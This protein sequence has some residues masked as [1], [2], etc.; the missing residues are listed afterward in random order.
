MRKLNQLLERN[1]TGK[2]VLVLF[3][4]TSGIY[5]FMLVYTIP[6]T[7]EYANGLKLLDMMPLGYDLA[8]VNQLFNALGENGRIFYL[9]TQIPV[10]MVYPFMFGISYSL[11]FG[12]FLR[13][14]AN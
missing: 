1:I 2:K 6:K 14:W 7:M 5:S 13:S 3:L 9:T 8:Y 10:D 4:L 11:I 12:Y